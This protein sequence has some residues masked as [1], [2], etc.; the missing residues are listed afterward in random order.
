MKRSGSIVKNHL[1]ILA[2]ILLL[3]SCTPAYVP[4]T[5]NTPLMSNKGEIQVGANVGLSGFDPQASFAVTD[6]V[7][8]MLNGS[9]RNSTS[10]SSDSF[11]KHVFLEGGCGYFTKIGSIGR[12][13]TFG[14]YGFSK[15]QA[16]SEN[17]I[18]ASYAD[19][20]CNRIF[21]QPAIGIAT[22]VFDGSFA[23]R[24][25]MV[26]MHQADMQNTGFFLEPALTLKLGYKYVKGMLQFGLSFPLNSEVIDFNYQPFLFSVG[27]QATLKRTYE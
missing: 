23:T 26:D 20:T 15:L 14:G 9:F 19:A 2:I 17:G 16:Y 22:K 8:L 24:M 18:W 27:L 6:H 25:V 1:A 11:H 4:N 21:I 3:A 13:E 5:L 7:G 10:D 12:F